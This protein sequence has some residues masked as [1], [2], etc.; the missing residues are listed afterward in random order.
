[1]TVAA[2]LVAELADALANDPALA[3][4]LAT[5]IAPYL[6]T[7]AAVEDGWLDTRAAAGYAGCTVNALHKAMAARAVAFEQDV[8]GGKCWFR[9]SDIDAWRTAS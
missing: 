8:A 4:E 3:A 7:A 2:A 1:M 9:R 5:T 6:P